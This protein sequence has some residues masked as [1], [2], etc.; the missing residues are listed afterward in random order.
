MQN[1][2]HPPPTKQQAMPH[3]L[4]ALLSLALTPDLLAEVTDSGV[5]PRLLTIVD[6]KLEGCAPVAL[7]ILQEMCT[8]PAG[9]AL[10]AREGGAKVLAKMVHADEP[11]SVA[12][13]A[14]TGMFC[15]EVC[16]FCLCGF[17]LGVFCLGYTYICLFCVLHPPPVPFSHPPPPISTHHLCPFLTH[18]ALSLLAADPHHTPLVNKENVLGRLVDVVARPDW[19]PRDTSL[20]ALAQLAGLDAAGQYAVVTA[21]VVPVVVC[22]YLG[23]RVGGGGGGGVWGL[24]CGL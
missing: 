7:Q 10:V 3:I 15:G 9:R 17:C 22:G 4:D 21:G 19:S 12:D 1:F 24:A 6:R 14:L 23:V 2:M 18:T 16:G 11:V 8:S 20:H 13:P 5:T